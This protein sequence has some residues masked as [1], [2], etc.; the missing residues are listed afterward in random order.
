IQAGV[1]PGSGID[2]VF[3]VTSNS[4]VAFQNLTI[5]NGKADNDNG[6]GILNDG[7][8]LTVTNSTFSGNRATG[9]GGGIHNADNG[10]LTV[11]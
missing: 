4:T 6:G 3:H 2:R 7:G 1:R 11:T 8:T 5:A 10:A 9:A